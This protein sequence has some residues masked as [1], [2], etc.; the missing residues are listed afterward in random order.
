MASAALV[1][2]SF[3]HRTFKGMEKEASIYESHASKNGI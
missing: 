2:T 3:I 1:V